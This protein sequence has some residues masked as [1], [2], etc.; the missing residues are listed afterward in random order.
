[1]SEPITLLGLLNPNLT[2]DYEYYSILGNSAPPSNTYVAPV[3]PP[4]P[5][6]ASL[7]KLE[8]EEERLY[9]EYEAEYS[10]RLREARIQ[11]E[12][13]RDAAV[14]AGTLPQGSLIGTEYDPLS[15]SLLDGRIMASPMQFANYRAGVKDISM[16]SNLW[17]PEEKELENASLLQNIGKGV[18]ELTYT[19][20]EPLR[21]NFGLETDKSQFTRAE[22][23]TANN[24]IESMKRELKGRLENGEEL[25]DEDALWLAENDKGFF[26]EFADGVMSIPGLVETLAS[27]PEL[28][29]EFFNDIVARMPVSV[30]GSKGLGAVAGAARNIK[31]LDRLAR[32]ASRSK[33]LK[34]AGELALDQIGDAATDGLIEHG[35]GAGLDAGTFGRELGEGL[36]LDGALQTGLRLGAKGVGKVLEGKST[37]AGQASTV[38]DT[39]PIQEPEGDIRLQAR[40]NNKPIDWEGVEK[41]DKLNTVKKLLKKQGSSEALPLLP[42][43]QK[44]IFE[45]VE[46]FIV[47][48]GV[49]DAVDGRKVNL[50]NPDDFKGTGESLGQRAEHL[51]TSSMQGSSRNR[52]IDDSRIPFVSAIPRTVSDADLVATGQH[53]GQDR[54][55]YFKNYDKG[56]HLVVTDKNGK[57]LEQGN[58]DGLLTQYPADLRKEF[59]ESFRVSYKKRGVIADTPVSS[60]SPTTEILPPRS[61]S[62]PTEPT[63]ALTNPVGVDFATGQTEGFP[64]YSG[65]IDNIQNPP[66]PIPER[67]FKNLLTKLG[68]T[69]LA[70]EVVTDTDKMREALERAFGK[71]GAARFMATR[72]YKQGWKENNDVADN[73]NYMIPP[74]ISIEYFNDLPDF[75]DL[76]Y[77]SGFAD[78]IKRNMYPDFGRLDQKGNGEYHHFAIKDGNSYTVPFITEEEFNKKYPQRVNIRPMAT[79]AGEVYGF[80]TT[81]GRIFLDPAK[82]NAN[83]PVHEYGHLW[84][85][86]VKRGNESLYRRLS[87][88]ARQSDFYKSLASNPSYSH[89]SEQGRTEEAIAHAIGNKG[90]GIYRNFMDKKW[91]RRLISELWEWIAGK[92]GLRDN[93]RSL[94]P[95]QLESMNFGELAEGAAK[96]IMAGKRISRDPNRFFNF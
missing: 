22:Q 45:Q 44:P 11:R 31:N 79:L 12:R 26:A 6:R 23:I 18:G 16:G 42:E 3:Q 91:I 80:A 68:K 14:A 38:Q 74:Y 88:A 2:S 78:G 59:D 47:R 86:F 9:R 27:D 75:S 7:P 40:Q 54:I 1:M 25:S 50:A 83:T 48:Q 65:D 60:L 30:V 20:T 69:A 52:I 77:S 10:K 57:V 28:R 4:P 94:T 46:D 49:V 37:E 8:S 95:E 85:D 15:R 17:F 84:T 21:K 62:T 36:G 53:H 87:V 43:S 73:L 34:A 19:I 63:A 76:E 13:N 5:A 64:N 33:A 66:A 24:E 93:I 39:Q 96:D 56:T 67:A 55:Y 61:A 29:R 58:A 72:F 82:M 71:E 41:G 32:I 90:D 35:R 51:V 70:K 81:D 89:L 92:L